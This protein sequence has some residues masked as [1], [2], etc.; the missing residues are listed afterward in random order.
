LVRT[1]PSKKNRRGAHDTER[2]SESSRKVRPGI[3]TDPRA[4]YGHTAHSAPGFVRTH[5]LQRKAKFTGFATLR[6]RSKKMKDRH[7]QG[8]NCK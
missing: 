3:T 4:I 7:C 1:N 2:L 5:T 8:E 6:R